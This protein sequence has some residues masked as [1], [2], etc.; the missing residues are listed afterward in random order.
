M[1]TA[2]LVCLLIGGTFIAG[3]A[4]FGG[5]DHGD[6]DSDLDHDVSG[7]L[8][9]EVDAEAG[10]ELDADHGEAL[11]P[12]GEAHGTADTAP[13]WLPFL[14]MRFWTFFLAFFGLTGTVLTGL[15]LWSSQLLIAPA[16]LAMG[17]GSG[18]GVSAVL[19]RLRR[20][21][22]SSS[23]QEQDYIGATGRVLLP[24][25]RGQPGKVRLELQGR[26]LDLI[27][28][29]DDEQMLGARQE[30]LVYGM[31]RGVAKVTDSGLRRISGPGP[32]DEEDLE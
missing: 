21:T 12:V 6:A 19:G 14:S 29:T 1:L 10:A 15:G 2:Y 17:L 25:S 28:E 31:E 16:S 22:I 9:H 7:G 11:V 20:Q 27:A 13:L 18:Y 26:I 5:Q 3:S 8:D 30:V 4:L 23:L 24:I 32:A